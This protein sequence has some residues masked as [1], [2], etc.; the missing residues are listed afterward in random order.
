MYPCIFFIRRK[1]IP[2]NIVSLHSCCNGC[3]P[4]GM[5]MLPNVS[6]IARKKEI[7]SYDGK[8]LQ[9]QYPLYEGEKLF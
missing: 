9:G 4:I 8:N 3:G 7:L 1:R 2:K 5:L 6:P